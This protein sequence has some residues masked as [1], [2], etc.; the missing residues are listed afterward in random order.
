MIK[1]KKTEKINL[2][3]LKDYKDKKKRFPEK[4]N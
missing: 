2:K 3:A 4:S 1:T